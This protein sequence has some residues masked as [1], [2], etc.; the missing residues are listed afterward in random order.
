LAGSNPAPSASLLAT[1]GAWSLLQVAFYYLLAFGLAGLLGSRSYTIGVLLA[2]QL[3]LTP[4]IASISSL[5]VVREF[6]PGVGLQD[7]APAA[8]GGSV[9]MVMGPVMSISI[10]ATAA[11]L[12][13]WV[14]VTIAAGA[15]RDTTRDA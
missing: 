7:L 15:R 10:A 12:M 4:L 2:W 1:T 11:V 5:G 9:Y 8:L 3:A 13:V 14:T 6:V